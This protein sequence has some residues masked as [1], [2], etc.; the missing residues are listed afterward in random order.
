M[1]TQKAALVTEPVKPIEYPSS[2]GKPMAETDIH[3]DLMA[4][5]IHELD[6]YFSD[7]PDVYVSGNLLF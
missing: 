4:E 6:A 3:R 2:D 5:L 1:S 7:Q